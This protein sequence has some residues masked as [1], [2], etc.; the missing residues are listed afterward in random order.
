MTDLPLL[1]FPITGIVVARRQPRNAV[2]WVLLGIGLA[3]GFGSVVGSYAAYGL[4]TNP[5]SLPGAGVAAALNGPMWDPVIVPIA[6]LLLL[7]FPDGRPP[8]RR[9]NW[10]LWLTLFAVAAV[11]VVIMVSPGPIADSI[12]G[13]PEGATNPI[14]V[15]LISK[16]LPV[17][18]PLI[19]VCMVLSVTSLIVRF[20]RSRGIERL[21]LKWLSTAAAV[22]VGL[23]ALADVP[24]LVNL[25][26]KADPLWLTIIQNLSLLAFL[27]IPISIGLAILRYH[28]YDIDRIISR[29][30]SYFLLTALLVGMY[31][32]IVVGIGTLTGRNNNPVLI[33][34]A[35][36]LVAALF[37]PLRRR[38]QRSIDRRLYRRRYDAERV[39]GAFASL[40]R[41]ELDLSALSCELR[42][43]VSQTVQPPQRFACGSGARGGPAVSRRTTS[44]IAW[45]IG[46]VSLGIALASLVLWVVYGGHAGL[47][48]VP[49]PGHRDRAFPM[50]GALV[51][52]GRPENPV[53]WLM[54]VVGLGGALTLASGVSSLH[55]GG[56]PAI[57]PR[58]GLVVL[59]FELGVDGRLRP[60]GH[61]PAPDLPAG[62][63]AVPPVA[64]GGGSRRGRPGHHHGHRR[65]GEP[66]RDRD[67]PRAVGAEPARSR[68]GMTGC[69]GAE[70][71]LHGRAWCSWSS[72]W[73]AWSGG[74]GPRGACS[75]SSLRGSRT[76]SRSPSR[77]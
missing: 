21:Q 67:P 48:V 77:S 28:L 62:N 4:V 65:P 51:A 18:L 73:L 69:G 76:R 5:G 43:A 2:V 11:F 9:W 26:R 15:P 27:L 7:L 20:R 40:L 75:G 14:A 36:L 68:S 64:P 19:P 63:A 49:R 17:V 54:L 24:S 3:G 29:T 53:G 55:G 23:Y 71:R 74:T 22:G 33:A 58:R 13:A 61:G 50:V 6:T 12:P 31:A 60:P 59:G 32:L 39:L 45:T 56:V 10:V 57:A 35:T 52:A 16:L 70:R 37:G 30:V 1:V 44:V 38:L 47:P 34:G 42:A 46:F 8:S 41:D 25:G 66:D 72:A